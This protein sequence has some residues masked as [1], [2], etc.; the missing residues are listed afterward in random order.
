MVQERRYG[1][2]RTEAERRARHKRLFGTSKLPPRGTGLKLKHNP[3]PGV[4]RRLWAKLD[5]CVDKVMANP[6]FRR[7]YKARIKKIGAK[8]LAVAICRKTLKI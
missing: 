6:A 7:R 4:P 3:Y 2:P 1:K 8:S 5:R